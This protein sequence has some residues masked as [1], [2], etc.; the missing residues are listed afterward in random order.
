MREKQALPLVQQMLNILSKPYSVK[1]ELPLMR[2][3]KFPLTCESIHEMFHYNEIERT[4]SSEKI[5][6]PEN[7]A[8]ALLV[9]CKVTHSVITSIIKN[10]CPSDSA[11]V[12]QLLRRTA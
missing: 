9:E 6:W 3:S 8:K 5:V 11:P 2:H 4:A 12:D 10:I 1:L 7:A